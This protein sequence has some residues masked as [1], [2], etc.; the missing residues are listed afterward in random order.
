MGGVERN[1][2]PSEKDCKGHQ[3]RDQLN[4]EIELRKSQNFVPINGR[5]KK[6]VFNLSLGPEDRLF[7]LEDF[8][9]NLRRGTEWKRMQV[10]PWI[11]PTMNSVDL[12]PNKDHK[13]GRLS[14]HETTEDLKSYLKTKFKEND[15][16]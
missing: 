6:K 1:P 4:S 8:E 12:L 11:V 3:H 2:G 7:S 9:E 10:C 14:P 13:K 5:D 16:D 15:S